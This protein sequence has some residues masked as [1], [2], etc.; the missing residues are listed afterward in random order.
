MTTC[1][2]SGG[3]CGAALGSR[4][5]TNLPRGGGRGGAAVGPAGVTRTTMTSPRGRVPGRSRR[6]FLPSHQRPRL[7][8]ERFPTPLP[9]QA[10]S[11]A[12]SKRDGTM[13]LASRLSLIRRTDLS[14]FTN[15][16]CG[17]ERRD[18]TPERIGWTP[19]V[20]QNAASGPGRS[21]HAWGC[22]TIQRR[23][24]GDHGRNAQHFIPLPIRNHQLPAQ[25]R[26]LPRRPP[27]P[28]SAAGPW[29]AATNM[30]NKSATPL[31]PL[32]PKPRPRIKRHAELVAQHLE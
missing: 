22:A 8:S 24:R 10:N 11:S 9:A 29:E 16:K 7:V 28:P 6:R 13:R 5:L 27:P 32:R 19:L 4:A 23:V 14:L 2:R 1:P 3:C 20:E 26:R 12:T 30:N 25:P 15:E 31:R 21:R 18:Y 17:G